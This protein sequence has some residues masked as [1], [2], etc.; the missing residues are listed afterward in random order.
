[1]QGRVFTRHLVA[2]LHLAHTHC[3]EHSNICA[4]LHHPSMR[5]LA[6][7]LTKASATTVATGGPCNTSGVQD[8]DPRDTR[9]RPPTCQGPRSANDSKLSPPQAPPKGRVWQTAHDRAPLKL[10]RARPLPGGARV[11][12]RASHTDRNANVDACKAS[13]ANLAH[14]TRTLTT[15]GGPERRRGRGPPRCDGGLCR[16]A[17]Y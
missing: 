10:K 14:V 16:C 3:H 6:M 12:C 5:G 17:K 1:M 7:R 8:P 11:F 13:E 2:L 15:G 9:Q 4:S